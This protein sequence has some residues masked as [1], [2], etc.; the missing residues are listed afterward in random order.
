MHALTQIGLFLSS[1]YSCS[2]VEYLRICIKH[3]PIDCCGMDWTNVVVV[4]PFIFSLGFVVATKLPLRRVKLGSM[5]TLRDA[6]P[7][8][9]T[10]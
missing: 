2:I 6:T 3:Y 8:Q 7:Q 10:A 1:S 4:N 5:L 9:Y